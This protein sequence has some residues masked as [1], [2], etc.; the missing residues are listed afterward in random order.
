MTNSVLI[1][2]DGSPL[3]EQALDFV[4][5]LLKPDTKIRLLTVLGED[6]AV[7]LAS[8]ASTIGHVGYFSSELPQVHLEV[9]P[10]E[11]ISARNYLLGMAERLE[12]KGYQVTVEVLEG[13][14]VVEAIVETANT[15]GYD[16]VFMVT[17]GRT[18]LSKLA[19]GSVTEGV[20]KKA[21]CP[22]IVVPGHAS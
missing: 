19:L 6:R 21:K 15:G 14:S 1:T 17:H 9:D 2:L 13:R 11:A 16:A 12:M 5:R 22:V 18:G 8:L 7:E 4:P 10:Q 20:L 3:A